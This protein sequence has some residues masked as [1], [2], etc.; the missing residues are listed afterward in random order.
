MALPYI[1]SEA[2]KIFEAKWREALPENGLPSS[3]DI[4]RADFG[5]LAPFLLKGKF[6]RPTGARGEGARMDI[7]HAGDGIA[8]RL[9]VDLT[10]FEYFCRLLP[11]ERALIV[12]VFEALFD[13]DCGRWRVM[14]YR[15]DQGLKLAVDTTFFP[16]YCDKTGAERVGA[17]IVPAVSVEQGAS[18]GRA[19]A[20][21]AGPAAEWIGLGAG[22]PDHAMLSLQE[23]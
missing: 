20:A 14:F 23:A 1:R 3:L 15:F 12:D 6:T 11:D 13:H 18:K 21:E 17:L 16:Y 8:T 5:A 9:N 7:D 2:S 19:F 4:D 10:G 22:I